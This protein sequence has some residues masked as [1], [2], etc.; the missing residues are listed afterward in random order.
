MGLTI[1]TPHFN[2]FN[3]IKVLFDNLL[4]QTDPSW[5]WLIIDDFSTVVIKNQLDLFIRITNDAR[6]QIIF[7]NLKSNASACR[8]IGIEHAI[9]EM[10]VFVDADDFLLPD[11]VENRRRYNS[12]FIVYR[13]MAI[14]NKR[15]NTQ[16]F[17]NVESNYL[18]HFLKANFPWQT[19]AVVWNKEF[20]RRISGFNIKLAHFQDI[21]L[22]IRGLLQGDKYVIRE[23]NTIDFR[24]SVSPIN[25]IKRPI[26][27]VAPAAV[28]VV[29]DL[30]NS[31]LL[32][33]SQIKL[34]QAYYFVC[35]RYWIRGLKKG[36]ASTVMQETL[37]KF[38]EIGVISRPKF[39][40]A[41]AL[42]Y[43]Y[44]KSMLSHNIFLKV[45]RK[46]FKS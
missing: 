29:S 45:N 21:D 39:I 18:E 26:D 37:N 22:S 5:Q 3:G 20:L 36:A 1:I 42:N 10:I 15:G 33:T 7:R 34:L 19:S 6:I 35:V 23:D 44:S 9:N 25:P 43:L 41:K 28:Q 16:L 38:H 27:S 4:K 32:N 46:L 11:F 2:S 31:D 14:I 40:S 30:V 13:N 8:N 17:S 24:Y 12:N